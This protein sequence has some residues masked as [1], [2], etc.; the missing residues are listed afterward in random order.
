MPHKTALEELDGKLKDL[1][2]SHLTMGGI[3]LFYLVIL[4]K[5]FLSPKIRM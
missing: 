4:D 1:R 5:H 3:L 2:K